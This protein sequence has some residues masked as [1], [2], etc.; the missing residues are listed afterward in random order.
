MAKVL[1]ITVETYE[2]SKLVL[3]AHWKQAE[4]AVCKLTWFPLQETAHVWLVIPAL[5]NRHAVTAFQKFKG[6]FED[7][8]Q[9]YMTMF[10]QIMW[11]L[12]PVLNGSSS[13]E[14]MLYRLKGLNPSVSSLVRALLLLKQKSVATS[15]KHGHPGNRCNHSASPQKRN[16][17]H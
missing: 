3:R 12:V 9:A 15:S 14:M 2:T 5:H 11:L 10:Q 4:V 13:V 6:S 16:S 17:S 7:L 1:Q 8:K